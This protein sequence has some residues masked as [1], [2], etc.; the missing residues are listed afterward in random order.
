M[1][2]KLDKATSTKITKRFSGMWS[3]ADQWRSKWQ[4]ISEYLCPERGIFDNDPNKAF[5]VDNQKIIDST[6]D[7]AL[8]T[9]AAGLA[10]G[11]SSPSR[12]WFR[13]SISD[14]ELSKYKP[15]KLWMEDTTNRMY[16][17]LDRSNFYG[18]CVQ[19]YE[20]TGAFGTGAMYIGEDYETVIRCRTFTVGEYVI[21][22]DS[23]NRVNAF[24]R[25]IYMTV[26]N[27]IEEFGEANVSPEVLNMYK[28]NEDKNILLCNLID[29]N[30]GRIPGL[31]DSSNMP[32]RSIWWEDG[33]LS[34][35]QLRVSGF[36]EFPVM[37]PRWKVRNT[38]AIYGVSPGW[39][40]IGDIRMLQKQHVQKIL[41][42]DLVNNPPTQRDANVD[43]ETSF[44]PGSENFYSGTVP[45]GGV[46]A[47]YQIN[48]DLNSMRLDIQETQQR[49][50]RQFFYDLFLMF[51]NDTRT[52][53]TATEIIKKFQEKAQVLG[54]ALE[55]F[56]D[57]FLDPSLARVYGIMARTGQVAEPPEEL[58]GVNFKFEYTSILAQAQK[59]EGV[60]AVEQFSQFALGMMQAF[61]ESGDVVDPDEVIKGVGE[62]LG[63]P[64]SMVRDENEV[65]A[66]RQQRAKQQQAAA[67]Q[68]RINQ[69]I[70]G[71]KTMSDT[72]MGNTTALDAV[73][74]GEATIPGIGQ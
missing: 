17:V 6:G 36:E 29:K 55:S 1:M 21:G 73:V 66:I 41:A 40:A 72:P 56:T 26:F 51:Q 25:K 59:S 16:S 20:E 64:V 44:L 62:K 50:K 37:V 9:L 10:S 57:D 35:Y 65:A 4:S 2:Q 43:G 61:P 67:D 27:M 32:Y 48:P 74:N 28:N 58:A 49:I 70:A 12:P 42:S 18:S 33:K 45:N 53:V 68:E 5:A 60:A 14:K 52:G 13:I 34:Q 22:L 39:K 71:A 47:A 54:P 11:M 8:R 19:I 38:S 23:T 31:K 69:T 15:V 24:G 63:V 7:D 46:R 3:E 30:S